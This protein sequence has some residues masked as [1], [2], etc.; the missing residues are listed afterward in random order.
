MIGR[1]EF[2]NGVGAAFLCLNLGLRPVPVV[3]RPVPGIKPYIYTITVGGPGS[4]DGD[5]FCVTVPAD[6]NI[7]AIH[8]RCIGGGGGGGGGVIT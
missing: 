1:R 2:L 4:G 5:E 7:Y 6:P 3:R 8:V